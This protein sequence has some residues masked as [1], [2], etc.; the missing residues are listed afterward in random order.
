MY[1]KSCAK[2][3]KEGVRQ[4]FAALVLEKGQDPE[5]LSKIK[6]R[7]ELIA[8]LD[9]NSRHKSEFV[10]KIVDMI[11]ADSNVLNEPK[12]SPV[13]KAP[14]SKEGYHKRRSKTE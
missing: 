2:K 8:R 11:L 9:K 10:E 1:L 7:A 13:K 4:R 5:S 3:N 6:E 14:K 12:Y